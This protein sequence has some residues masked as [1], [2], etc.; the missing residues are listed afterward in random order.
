MFQ[1][2]NAYLFKCSVAIGHRG[3]HS[4]IR[5]DH[6]YHAMIQFLR[7]KIYIIGCFKVGSG[8]ELYQCNI[9]IK[10]V[11]VKP[12]SSS[13]TSKSIKI[14]KIY[15]SSNVHFDLELSYSL[16]CYYYE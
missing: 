2:L 3:K 7:L 5:F 14:N 8:I 4:I 9:V 16:T 1:F 15:E 6:A 12:E 10:F 11:I 13:S